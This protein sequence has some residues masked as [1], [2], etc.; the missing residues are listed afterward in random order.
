M[1]GET[2]K[3]NQSSKSGRVEDL[4]Q[5]PISDKDAQTVKGGMAHKEPSLAPKK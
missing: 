2:K 3:P 4:S 1:S 5:K